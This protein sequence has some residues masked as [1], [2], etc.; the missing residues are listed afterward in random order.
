[1][2]SNAT[3]CL[4]EN[5]KDHVSPD[6]ILDELCRWLDT[7]TLNEALHDICKS[8]DLDIE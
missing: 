2:D 8:F 5:M 4:L 7:E 3:W 6:E 1:M